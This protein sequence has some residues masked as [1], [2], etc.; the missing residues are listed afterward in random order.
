VDRRSGD[1]IPLEQPSM[2]RRLVRLWTAAPAGAAGLTDI[3][4]AGRHR[5]AGTAS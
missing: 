3:E 4:G 2:P 5:A 1:V